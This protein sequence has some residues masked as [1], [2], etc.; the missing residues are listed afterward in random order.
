MIRLRNLSIHRGLVEKLE[1]VVT[2]F[3]LLYFMGVQFPPPVPASLVNALS[4]PFIAILVALHWKRLFWVGTRDI[5]LL[6]LVGI[7]LASFFWSAAPELTLDA[8]RGLLRM[9][10]F[11]AYLATRYSIKEQMKILTWVFA[12]GATLSLFFALAVPSYGISPVDGHRGAFIGIFPYK[13]YMSYSMVLGAITFLLVAL[14]ERKPNWLAWSGFFLTVVLSVLTRSSSGLACLLILL[15]LMPLYQLIRLH[16]KP[17]VILLC[18]VCIL[19][20]SAA[21]IILGNLETILVDILGESVTFSGRTPIWTLVI[22]KV[23]EERPWLGYGVNA[24]WKSDAGLFVILNT[25]ASL[26]Q[27]NI[28]NQTFNFHNAYLVVFSGLG[29]LGLL[30]YVVSF[31]IVFIR[32]SYFITFNQKVRIFLVTS[33]PYIY[34]YRRLW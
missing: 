6:L 10:L 25:W 1:V 16:Y 2:V 32:V 28:I 27:K 7:S 17:K 19:A 15:A 3:W 23:I 18:L 14:Q 11:G 24:F 33:I 4:Y 21:I 20:G 13:N 9:I 30:F 34:S 12:I 5:I 8:N 26:S 31:L 22:E 29:F